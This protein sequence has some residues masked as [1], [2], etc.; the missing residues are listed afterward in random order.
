MLPPRGMVTNKK[1]CRSHIW[2]FVMTA[3]VLWTA[4]CT[5]PGPRALL[6]G[7]RLME[8]GQ[9]PA[10]I[11]KLKLATSLMVTNALAWNYLGLAYH[12]GG[13][14]DSAVGAYERALKINHDLVVT[15]YNL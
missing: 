3:A 14:P 4:G 13:Q 10:A 12:H 5:P 9:Y 7:K 2:L 15:H 11:E 1:R 6:D 8:E